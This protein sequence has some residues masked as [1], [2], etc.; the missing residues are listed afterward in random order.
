[1]H[2]NSAALAV[3]PDTITTLQ[4]LHA[5]RNHHPAGTA[6]KTQSPH[7]RCCMQEAITTLQV[8]HARRNHHPA[9]A[10]CQTLPPYCKCWVPGTIAILQDAGDACQA[11]PPYCRCWVP[12]AIAILQVMHARRY[13]HTAGAY[14]SPQASIQSSRA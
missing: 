13:R 4:V 9:V 3:S 5:R 7:C 1:M 10:G 2:K 8:L 11:I 6:C 14:S 12:G